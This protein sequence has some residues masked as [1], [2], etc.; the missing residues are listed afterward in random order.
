M[1]KGVPVK[2]IIDGEEINGCN[3][4]IQVPKYGLEFNIKQ[5]EQTIEFTPK[6]EGTI[7][8][9]CWMGMIP[10]TFIVK[11]D[12]DLGDEAA[13][14]LAQQEID[15]APAPQGG[16]C[17]GS[18]GGSSCGAASGGSCGCGG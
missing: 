10:G 4:A 5:G 7:R 16:S 8:W 9:S 14:E 15:N 13:V 18:C 1:K 2:W 3:N 6:E 12:L 11:E 17:G